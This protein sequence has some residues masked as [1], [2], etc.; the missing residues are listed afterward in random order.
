MQLT[1]PRGVD[2]RLCVL[3]GVPDKALDSIVRLGVTLDKLVDECQLDA[4]AVRCWT[5][6]QTQL[7]ISPCVLMGALNDKGVASSCE[8]DVGNAVAMRA[9]SLA[10]RE[11]AACLD[12][13]NNYADDDD[14]CILF[15]CGPVPASL[16]TGKG[17][18]QRRDSGECGRRWQRLW[19]HRAYRAKV[20]PSAA[21]VG[22]GQAQDAWARQVLSDP[23]PMTFRLRGRGRDPPIFR[24]SCCTLA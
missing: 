7:G 15:H 1:R 16:M 11:P 22:R 6:M 23:I 10:S 24:R 2:D 17:Q 21:D 9:L 8:V 3:E 13:N 14:K 20:L 19:L 12:W 4:L 18:I 5:E